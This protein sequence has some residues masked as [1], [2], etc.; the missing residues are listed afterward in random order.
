ME[1]AHVPKTQLMVWR[2]FW[3]HKVHGI[4]LKNSKAAISLQKGLE[5]A[6]LSSCKPYHAVASFPDPTQLSIA[7]STVNALNCR[8]DR[9]TEK[10]N[11][12]ISYTIQLYLM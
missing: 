6:F 7:F 12:D 4:T 3:S 2:N 8:R 5:P 1:V 9:T 10:Y 11:S